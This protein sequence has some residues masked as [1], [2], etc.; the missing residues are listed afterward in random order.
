MVRAIAR[1]CILAGLARIAAAAEQDQFVTDPQSPELLKL[2]RPLL[3]DESQYGCGPLRKPGKTYYVSL[4]GRDEAD[5]LAWD[6]AWRHV[7]HAFGKLRAGDTLIIGEGEYLEKPLVLDARMGQTGEPGRPI[8]IMAAPRHRVVITAAVRPELRRTPGTRFTWEATMELKVGRATLWQADTEILLQ[9]AAGLDI[10]EELPATWWY[11]EKKQKTHVHFSDSRADGPRPVAVRLGRPSKSHFR[12]GDVCTVDVRADYIRF[13]GLGFRHAN[14]CMVV[15]G[16]PQKDKNGVE[17]CLGGAHVTVEDCAFN[18]TWFA[19]LVLTEGARWC[20]IKGNYGTLTGEQGSLMIDG[21]AADTHDNLFLCNRLDPTVRAGDA[22]AQQGGYHRCISTYGYVGQRNHLIGNVMNSKNS[23][24][25]KYTVSDTVIQGNTMVGVCQTVGAPPYLWEK[26]DDRIVFRNNVFLGRVPISG[27]SMPSGGAGGNW[28]DPYRAF[29]NNFV[30]SAEKGGISVETARFADPAYLDYRLQSDSPLRGKALGGGDIGAHHR[31]RGRIFYVSTEGDDASPG[32]SARRPL[33]SLARAASALRAGDTLYVMPGAYAEVLTV[34]SSGRGDALITIRAWGKKEVSLPGIRISG[35]WIVLEGFTVSAPE[36]DGILITGRNVALQRCVAHRCGRCGVKA[37]GAPR[38][39]LNHC[40]LASNRVG[41]G[42]DKGS[43]DR[44]VRD[45]IFAANR[46][47][48]V[49]ISEDSSAGYLASHNCYFGEGL[50][51]VRIGA[52][53]GSIIAAPEFVQADK[54]YYRLRWDSPAAHLAPFGRAAGARPAQERTPTIESVNVSRISDDAAV[55]TWRTPR[56]ATTGRVRCRPKGGEK[57]RTS[58]PTESGTV[59]GVGLTGLKPSRTYEV[60]VQATSPRGAEAESTQSFTTSD[61]PSAPATY[62]VAPDGD[63][64][65]EGLTRATAWRTIRKACTE[66]GPGDTVLFQPGAYHGQFLPARCGRRGQPITFRAD[67]GEVLIDGAGVLEPFVKISDGAYVTLDGF[68]FANAPRDGFGPLFCIDHS[69]GI[70]IL[71]C[72]VGRDRPEAGWAVCFFIRGSHDSRIEG[73]VVWGTRYHVRSWTNRNLVIKNNTFARGQVFSVHVHAPNEGTRVV[74]NIFYYPTT[75]PNAALAISH[76][77]RSIERVVLTSD[78]NLFGPM[79]EGTQVAYVYRVPNTDLPLPG[80]TLS[81]W[82]KNSGQDLHSVQ[83]DPL[84]VNP[85]AGDFR[86]RPGS[87]AIGAGEGGA[88]IGACGVAGVSIRGRTALPLAEGRT[89]RLEAQFDEGGVANVAFEWSLPGGETRRG[90]TLEYTPSGDVTRFTVK[91]TATD[92][93]GQTSATDETI[94]VAPA[95]AEGGIKVEAEDFVAQGGGE[96]EMF[97]PKP[98][99]SGRAISRWYRSDDHW[100]AWELTV[101]KNG[102]Y[103]IY[104]RYATPMEPTRS[105]ILNGASPGPA[106]DHIHFPSTHGFG[107]SDNE[108]TWA[109]KK[110]GPPLALKAGKHRFRMAY[111]VSA[112]DITKNATLHVD[113]FVVVRQDEAMGE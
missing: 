85:K 54:G 35:S 50:D 31:P 56:D 86:L 70:E 107:T 27:A 7:H 9:R 72:R 74:N 100:L 22:R 8:T 94:T 1:L 34:P 93:H 66:A 63:D 20:L 51:R 45:S 11:D 78:Y 83:V 48:A 61:K 62:Y 24:R 80:P 75:V 47:G 5:G 14:V 82:R 79:R 84:F 112:Q 105:F 36:G 42:L 40:T 33:A 89:I 73:N 68:T 88:N 92:Q 43:I 13:K 108:N 99:G 109:F 98:I 87:P 49:S 37:S 25:C 2:A 102:R 46:S 64:R 32:T 18:S 57:W 103:L 39:A 10:V 65:A 38:L 110:L 69:P 97:D 104:A 52:E 17:S 106:Y 91:L 55:I 77:D 111:Q 96:V 28:A 44:T 23:Y 101:P 21:G 95:G 41:L 53:I 19:G 113:Y 3:V 12:S 30:P 81:A 60:V 76:G 71:N 90:R 26:P 4:K 16:N 29:V 59:H 15:R 67:G 58:P 6:R